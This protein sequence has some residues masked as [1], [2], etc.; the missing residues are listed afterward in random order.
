MELEL[1]PAARE[2]ILEA[3]EWYSD[4]DPDVGR[5]F[6]DEVERILDGLELAPERW[7]QQRQFGVRRIRLRRFP[8]SVF[9]EIESGRVLVLA[10]AH[11]RR[12]PVSVRLI[13]EEVRDGDPRSPG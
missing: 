2:E 4:R 1:H 3:V 8:Y 10:V 6:G 7:P 13:A 12:R 11:A 9:Y 5:Q